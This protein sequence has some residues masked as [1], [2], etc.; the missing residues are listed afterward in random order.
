MRSTS[1]GFSL[2]VGSAA[3]V[4]AQVPC[5]SCVIGHTMGAEADGASAQEM[6]EAVAAQVR[7]LSTMLNGLGCDMDGFQAELGAPAAD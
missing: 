6:R 2:P 3:R 5:E 4:P 1:A 7:K